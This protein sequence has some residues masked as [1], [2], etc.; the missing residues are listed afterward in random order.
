MT[1]PSDHD[2][3][4]L[5]R[6]ILAEA[7]APQ[8]PTV[9]RLRART[10]MLSAAE[11]TELVVRARQKNRPVMASSPTTPPPPGVIG[12]TRSAAGA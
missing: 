7:D 12:R 8:S 10:A 5:V 3:D 11:R 9:D 2:V 4:V 6:N 1:A